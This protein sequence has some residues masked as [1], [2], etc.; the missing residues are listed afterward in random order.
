AEDSARGQASSGG[1]MSASGAPSLEEAECKFVW[2][3]DEASG[4]ASGKWCMPR[5]DV[6]AC[7]AIGTGTRG[8][9]CTAYADCA[10]GLLCVE[11]ACT[12]L[13]DDEAPCPDGSVCRQVQ[14]S[15]GSFLFR[16]C[17]EVT[18][19]VCCVNS[20]DSCSCYEPCPAEGLDLSCDV[21][22]GCCYRG[23]EHDGIPICVCLAEL[24]DG[25]AG[26][27]DFVDGQGRAQGLSLSEVPSC[28]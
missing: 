22:G 13:C 8:E 2:P 7:V 10:E 12:P 25:Y 24:P 19:E 23:L 18:A 27:S 28:P 1:M 21:A 11:A 14:S 6:T 15:S 9:P 26:C 3:R 20:G 17:R 4:C 5:V 16:M